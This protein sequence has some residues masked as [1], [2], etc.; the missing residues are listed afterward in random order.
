MDFNPPSGTVTFLFTDIEGSTKLWQQ[1]PKTMPDALAC[2]HA[3]LRE[4]VEAHNGYVFQIIGDAF[5]AAFSTATNGLEAALAAQRTLRD[6]TW[7]ETGEIRVRMSLHTGMAEVHA[8]EHTSG[9]Y[10]S[11]LTLSRAARLLSTGHGGQILLSLPT[12]ELVRE[13]LPA[14]VSLRDLE[15]HLLKDLV[16]PEH[17]YQAVVPDLRSEFLPLKSLDAHP[18]NLPIQLTS[19]IGREQE[20]DRVKELLASARLLTLTGSGGCGK[21]RLALQVAADLIDEFPDGVWF[22]EL[23]PLTDPGLIPLSVATALGLQMQSGRTIQSALMEYLRERNCLLLFDNCEH[24]IDACAKLADA[25]VRACPNLKIL[26]TSR[27]AFGMA[28]EV[29]FHVPSLAIPPLETTSVETLTQYESVRLFVERAVTIQPNFSVTNKNASSVA[30]ICY[31]LDGIPLALELAAARVNI[32]SV[33]QISERLDDCFRLL[34]GGSRTALPRQQTLRAL[35]DWSYSLLS[36]PERI[37]FERLSIF[38]GGCTLEAA[39][40]ICAGN[41]IESFDVLDPL[42]NLVAKSLVIVVRGVEG[43]VRYHMLETIRQYAREELIKSGTLSLFRDRHLDWFLNYAEEARPK[44]FSGEQV[45]ALNR[46]EAEH[47]N[48][49]AALT[50]SMETAVDKGL[51]LAAS[52]FRF[53]RLRGH[54]FDRLDWLKKLLAQPEALAPTTTRAYVLLGRGEAEVS[55]GEYAVAEKSFEESLQIYRHIG[56][57]KGVADA[58]GELGVLSIRQGDFSRAVELCGEGLDICRTTGDK[59]QIGPALYR[60]ANALRAKGNWIKATELLEESLPLLSQTGDI[61]SIENH[62]MRFADSA[63]DQ[64]SLESAHKFFEDG[65]VFFRITG[66]SHE[67]AWFLRYLANLAWRERDLVHAQTLYQESLQ[68][69]QD[70]KDKYC[71]AH[72]LDGLAQVENGKGNYEQAKSLAHQALNLYEQVGNKQGISQVQRTLGLAMMHIDLREAEQ[73]LKS[74]LMVRNKL[75]NKSDIADSVEALAKMNSFGGAFERATKLFT[76]ANVL[77]DTIS[78]AMTPAER[79]ES[80]RDLMALR[81]ELGGETFTAAWDEGSAMTLEQMIKLALAEIPV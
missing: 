31:R 72:T 74:S 42:Q 17:I 51:R 29:P 73:M 66:S 48:F 1:Y 53:W 20:M 27:E 12:A 8:G 4:A 75:R 23:S 21:T 80:D 76:A 19:F 30:K 15:A 58:L 5:C 39:E 50:W 38:S 28:G 41:G 47:D 64:G 45:G 34:T 24:M 14:D 65:L 3:I 11:N 68:I 56:D 78:F 60:L 43:P 40:S 71:T 16:R 7:G 25:L 13:A 61:E 46:L 32:L 37:L 79:A 70:L 69:V 2:H 33:E 59:S 35:I 63:H 77:R 81:A 55:Q 22:V 52:L 10:A 49:R 6:A 54:W 26:A 18:H 9:E 36:Q 44:L 57:G 67:I 62:I